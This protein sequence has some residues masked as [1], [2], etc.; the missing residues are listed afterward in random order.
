MA[1]QH[2]RKQPRGRSPVTRP[3]SRGWSWL[4][5]LAVVITAVGILLWAPWRQP[6]SVPPGAMIT[7]EQ[8]VAAPLFSLPSTSGAPVDLA[9]YLG[10]QP[11]V[12]VFYMG[13]F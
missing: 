8:S 9:A 7:P 4:V 2:Q 10:K 1:K 11:V 13:D 12:L 6:G 3:R 5:G